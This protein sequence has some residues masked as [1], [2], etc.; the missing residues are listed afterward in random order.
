M[1]SATR[2]VRGTRDR[3]SNWSHRRRPTAGR[4]PVQSTQSETGVIPMDRDGMRTMTWALVGWLALAGGVRAADKDDGFVSLF[5]GKDLAGWVVK[6]KAAGWQV[7]DGVLR[8][9]GAKGGDWLRSEKEY[10]D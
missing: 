7:K 2:C 5:N 9:E 1:S 10:G 8:S 4:F 3:W 6:G